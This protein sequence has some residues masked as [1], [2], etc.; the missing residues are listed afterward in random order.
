[1]R[2]NQFPQVSGRLLDLMIAELS[3]PLQRLLCAFPE[4]LRERAAEM[5]LEAAVRE[6]GRVIQGSAGK[7]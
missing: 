7:V 6:L 1:M 3:E 4:E 5:A 2:E